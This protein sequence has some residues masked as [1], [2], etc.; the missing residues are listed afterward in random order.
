VERAAKAAEPKTPEQERAAQRR[1]EKRA[2]R[3]A[4]GV[5]EA[6]RW[7]D[8]QVRHGIAGLDRAGYRHF[9]QVAA[10]LVDAQASALA[11]AVRRLGS[12]PAS[13]PGW[14]ERLLGELG[15]LRLLTEAYARLGELPPALAETVSSRV[16]QQP[17][18][19]QVLASAP[20]RD[21]WQVLGSR[22]EFE[23]RLTARRVWLLG[24]ETGRVALVLSFAAPGQALS[25]DLV[26]GTE[27][28]ADVCFYPGSGQLRA[29]VARKH[30]DPVRIDHPAPVTTVDE[31]LSAVA[32]G[33]AEDPWLTR[34][35]V[36]LRAALVPGERW[37]VVD[38]NGAA[39]PLA[40][41]ATA[42]WPMLA[43]TQGSTAVIA[44]EWGPDGLIPLSLYAE[45]AEGAVLA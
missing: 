14:E 17:G 11:S 28:D 32:A 7:L 10:R 45:R 41:G 2:D 40:P 34:T 30:S 5:S 4:D 26:V 24:R 8:D 35:L 12:L 23:E 37:Y 33:L 3:M 39:L 19:E 43:T 44:A 29:L 22:D 25:V 27:F 1:A 31:A 20:V 13:G 36:V 42:P 6:R 38:E 16:G 21:T 18:A 15:L 9:D